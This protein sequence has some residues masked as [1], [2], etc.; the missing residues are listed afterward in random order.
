MAADGYVNSVK[1]TWN[2]G[3]SRYLRAD[4]SPDV[5]TYLRFIVTGAPSGPQRTV[6]RI[7]HDW[8]TE[9]PPFCD[10]PTDCL[11]VTRVHVRSVEGPWDEAT[12][13]YE[14]AP[15]VGDVL[16]VSSDVVR[17]KDFWAEIDLGTLVEGDGVYDLALTGSTATNQTFASREG[18]SEER[19][20]P[21]GAAG[22]VAGR[23][24]TNRVATRS[25]LLPDR[26]RATGRRAA[27]SLQRCSPRYWSPT[28]ARSP[29]AP[30]GPP[31]SWAP[32]RSP[33]SR[34]R[35]GRPFTGSRP[36]SRT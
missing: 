31:T 5:R 24:C 16:G 29:F 11:H 4:G 12:L 17:R 20:D 18:R 26:E 36:R 23:P 2:Y 14:N 10:E 27:D 15:A 28:G 32:T 21:G 30:S 7:R 35:T 25:V 13:T 34:G 19:R 3:H 6:L 9:F 8:A 33:S 22:R 1:P